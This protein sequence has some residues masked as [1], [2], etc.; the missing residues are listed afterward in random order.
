VK[1][2]YKHTQIGYVVIGTLTAA[3]VLVSFILANTNFSAFTIEALVI[4]GLFLVVF[5]TL[6]VTI[7]EDYLYIRFGL[8]PIRK[9]VNL[10]DIESAQAVRNKWYYFL[11]IRLTPHGWLYAVSGLQ[12]VEI[13]MKKGNK[14][15]IGTDAPQELGEAIR[16]AIKGVS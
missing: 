12:A 7:R 11:G 1:E 14:F 8:S 3:A 4:I 15:R 6:T 10:H 5:S 2:R 13:K 9:R 16:Q